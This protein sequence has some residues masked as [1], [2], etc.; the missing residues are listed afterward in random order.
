MILINVIFFQYRDLW[1]T[2]QKIFQLPHMKHDNILAFEAAEQHNE[3]S[4]IECRLIT[5]YHEL[6]SLQEYLKNNTVTWEQLCLIS[7]TM[8]RG[9]ARLHEEILPDKTNGYKPAIAHRDFKSGN[10]L[11]KNDLSACIADFG[12]ALTF[13]CHLRED[14]QKQVRSV[15]GTMRD[16][17]VAG[18]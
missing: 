14:A 9:L 5:A 17:L 7:F 4:K 15:L 16:G 3:G 10:V 6:G 2:E 12:L 11:L 13:H 18:K 1:E 8:T